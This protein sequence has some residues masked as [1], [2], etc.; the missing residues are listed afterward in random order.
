MDVMQRRIEVAAGVLVD[1]VGRIFMQRRSASSHQGGLWEFPG[2]KLHGAE[3]PRDAL[4]REL[5]EEIGIG[6]LDAEPLV[7][8]EHAYPDLTVVLDVWLVTRFDGQIEAREGQPIRWVTL[9]SLADLPMPEADRPIIQA[10]HERLTSD[11]IA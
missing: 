4:I 6:V 10:I 1:G 11:G 8:V 7:R 3:S 9:E 5:A 2:G